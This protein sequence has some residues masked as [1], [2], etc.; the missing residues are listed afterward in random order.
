MSSVERKWPTSSMEANVFIRVATLDNVHH[1]KVFIT[2][3]IYYSSLCFIRRSEWG[4][5]VD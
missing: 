5:F 2:N 3:W 1:G 4:N